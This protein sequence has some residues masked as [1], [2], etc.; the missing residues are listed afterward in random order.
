MDLVVSS[1]GVRDGDWDVVGY[2]L[3]NLDL[4]LEVSGGGKDGADGL[5]KLWSRLVEVV[6][7]CGGD[8]YKLHMVVGNEAEVT[9]QCLGQD[10]I[11]S[12]VE[13]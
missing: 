5:F 4:F 13:G 2:N 6:G 7:G 9:N 12:V 11:D 1:F 3:H 10:S 8:S